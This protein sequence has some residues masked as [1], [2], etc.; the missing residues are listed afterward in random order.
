W[1]SVETDEVL[2][3]LLVPVKGNA[4]R[5]EVPI[6]ENYAPN[7]TVSIYLVKPGGANE[8]PLERFA[9]TDIDVRRPDRELK[10]APR[11]ASTTAKPGDVGRGEGRGTPHTKPVADVDLLVFAVD[12]A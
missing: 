1:V 9:Y 6:K 4:G 3:T 8:L 2:D 5:I 7:E 12:D 11:L 10:V